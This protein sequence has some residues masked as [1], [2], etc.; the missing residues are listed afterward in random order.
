MMNNKGCVACHLV[1]QPGTATG[2]HL[3]GVVTRRE[4]PWIKAMI[5][6][7]DSMLQNDSIAK[8]L[9][10][11]YGIPMLRIPVTDLEVRAIY[12]YLRTQP[13]PLQ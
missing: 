11:Q 13:E 1:E 7:P 12:E 6:R 4:W 10:A 2:P 3:A 8:E 9:L 5:S